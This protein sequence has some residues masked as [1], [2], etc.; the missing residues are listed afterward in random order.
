[1]PYQLRIF[2]TEDGLPHR[3]VNSVLQDTT[4]KIWL[5]TN[6]GI[7]GYDGE[8]F[9]LPGNDRQ[10]LMSQSTLELL[11]SGEGD[12]IAIRHAGA[13]LLFNPTEGTVVETPRLPDGFNRIYYREAALQT[14]FQVYR[15]P[16]GH[17]VVRRAG[18]PDRVLKWNMKTFQHAPFTATP[19][20]TLLRLRRTEQQLESYDLEGQLLDTRRLDTYSTTVMTLFPEGSRSVQ[21]YFPSER[22]FGEYL[23]N[24]YRINPSGE[25]RQLHFSTDPG[26]KAARQKTTA[27]LMVLEHSDGSYWVAADN[28]LLVFNS[29][30]DLIADF[31]DQVFERINSLWIPREL[32]EDRE[33]RV[34]CATSNGL[35]LITRHT[36]NFRRYFTEGAS[37]AVRGM[38]ELP[39]GEIL[40]GGRDST[41]RLNPF[42]GTTHPVSNQLPLWLC[43]G[44]DSLIYGGRHGPELTVY[45]TAG[46]HISRL[47][48]SMA[49]NALPPEALTVPYDDALRG[50]V[51]GGSTTGLFTA[52][53]FDGEWTHFQPK[54]DSLLFDDVE[55][56]YVKRGPEGLWV[57]GSEGLYLILDNGIA[58]HAILLP[59]RQVKHFHRESSEIFWLATTSGLLRYNLKTEERRE[60]TT[61][62]GLSSNVI[63]A[64]YP[65]DLGYLWLPSERGLMRF[66][67][68]TESVHTYLPQDGIA[69]AE[70]NTFSHLRA[71]DGTFYFGGLNGVTAFHPEDFSDRPQSAPLV[72]TQL[73]QY[74][75]S[76]K[77][78]IDRLPEYREQSLLQFTPTNQVFTARFALQNYSADRTDYAWRVEPGDNDW[79]YQRDN[80]VRIN[81]LPYGNHQLVIK[82]RTN[83]TSWT[84]TPLRIPLRVPRPLWQRWY[85]WLGIT[86]AIALLFAAYFRARTRRL[87]QE[88]RQLTNMVVERTR[89][90]ARRNE[91]LMDA[92]QVRD[93]ILA[94]ISHDLRAPLVSLRDISKKVRFLLQR[95]RFSEIEHLSTNIDA[96]VA[97]TNNLLENLLQ[98]AARQR[99]E[100]RPVITQFDFHRTLE[101][102]RTLFD[103]IAT[104]KNVGLFYACPRGTLVLADEAATSTILRN[105]LDNAIKF[106]PRGADVAVRARRTKDGIVIDVKDAGTGINPDRIP[107]LFKSSGTASTSGTAGEAGMGLGLPLSFELATAIGGTLQ[108]VES[109]PAGSTFRLTLPAGKPI[110]RTDRWRTDAA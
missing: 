47:N 109:S 100:L 15:T 85:F 48:I 84:P 91:E 62:D 8:D 60:Y 51:Y 93:R 17:A 76:E 50:V 45:N 9:Q 32:Y 105:L 24:V 72:L 26:S 34:W 102:L 20:Q 6:Q 86:A 42:N 28:S 16:D 11:P 59:N 89:E 10:P 69:D 40:V 1:M 92:N 39:S 68:R 18:Q 5:G 25:L 79:T 80:E 52:R 37:F 95:E 96:T 81:G 31:G 55:V 110:A 99:R 82:A 78:L 58:E 7:I 87:R 2:G 73:R 104:N 74:S 67:P 97:G 49:D 94:V 103:P 64:V 83:G 56:N 13:P 3:N 43:W 44:R 63:Y 54:N 33:G 21:E 30:G 57:A 70:F 22:T 77:E 14:N 107:D 65:D 27:V 71:S 106:S 46:T 108:L 88:R 98:W 35:L 36:T 41:F 19:W 29:A 101:E 53:E 66:D 23:D 12:V 38:L 75:S 4:G 90:L 61:N